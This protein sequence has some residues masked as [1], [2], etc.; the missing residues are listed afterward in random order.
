[1]RKLYTSMFL[2]VGLFAAQAQAALV[3]KEVT[4]QAEGDS[5]KLTGYIAYD[6]AKEGKRPGVMVVHEWWGHN[7]YA[8][9]RAEMLA[10]L[11]YVALAID[12][13]GDGKKA[14]HPKDAKAFMM[15][16]LSNMDVARARFKAGMELLK[17]QDATDAEKIAAMG[18]CFGGAVVLDAARQGMPLAGVASFHG[19]LGTESPAKKGDI[20]AAIA[21]FHGEADKMVTPDIVEAFKKEMTEAEA[22]LHFV[23]Y[24][25]VLHSFTNPDADEFGKKFEMPLAYDKAAD[26]DSW[27]QLQE[28]FA[29]IFK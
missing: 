29:K 20:K 10:E 28:F 16:A 26:E 14:E 21:V 6:D 8:R 2:A 5:A 4:Y 17:A 13:Y 18:Y 25:G 7:A 22:D 9:K 1:M 24:P 11:G 12:M 15:E 23:G 27:K 19:S 3:T